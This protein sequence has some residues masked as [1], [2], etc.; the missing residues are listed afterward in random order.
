M[1]GNFTAIQEMSEKDE[2][3]HELQEKYELPDGDIITVSGERYRRLEAL[4]QPSIVGKEASEIYDT[5][6][7]SILRCDVE[8][9][10]NLYANVALSGGTTVFPSSEERATEELTALMLFTTQTTVAYQPKYKRNEW[11]GDS[12]RSSTRADPPMR[13]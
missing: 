11:I 6:F 5:A 3:K 7:L 2:Q 10:K 13:I 12:E 4:V 9:G 1:A 8:F